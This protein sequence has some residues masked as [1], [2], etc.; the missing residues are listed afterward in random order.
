MN[1]TAVALRGGSSRADFAWAGYSSGLTT[2]TTKQ[3]Y[4]DGYL[5]VSGAAASTSVFTQNNCSFGLFP[6]STAYIKTA[7]LAIGEAAAD[8]DSGI[9]ECCVRVVAG[10]SRASAA[11]AF[12]VPR[13]ATRPRQ[14]YPPRNHGQHRNI[15]WAARLPLWRGCWLVQVE[16]KSWL[17][18][19]RY[20]GER[21]RVWSGP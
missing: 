19:S 12:C 3:A 9:L 14:K 10:V 8:I 2:Y 20:C 7:I 13:A 5:M 1:A 21:V 16:H 6:P 17:L 11:Y 15:I 18:S 4:A